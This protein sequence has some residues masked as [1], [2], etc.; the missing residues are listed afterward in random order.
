VAAIF[1]VPL[2]SRQARWRADLSRGF[3]LRRQ[4]RESPL[5]DRAITL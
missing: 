2:G 3:Y 1:A 5:N 4:Y